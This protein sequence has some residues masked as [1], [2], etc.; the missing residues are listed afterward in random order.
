VNE[1]RAHRFLSWTG[2]PKKRGGREVQ[3]RAKLFQED[4]GDLNELSR[5]GGNGMVVNKT[6]HEGTRKKGACR[7]MRVVSQKTGRKN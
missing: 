1:G 5:K 7:L 3:P 4:G 6:G 2:G